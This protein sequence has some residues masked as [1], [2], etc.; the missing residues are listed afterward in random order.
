[1]CQ[2]HILWNVQ[3]IQAPLNDPVAEGG[4]GNKS[5]S[6]PPWQEWDGQIKG[7]TQC[8]WGYAEWLKQR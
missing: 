5:A 7:N 8:R 2:L 3:T 4:R 6:D 1:M